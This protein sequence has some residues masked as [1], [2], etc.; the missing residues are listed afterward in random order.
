MGRYIAQRLVSMVPVVLLA[1]VG[2][3]LFFTTVAGRSRR[4]H[5]RHGR[6][7]ANT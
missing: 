2:V 3:F 4:L 1:S 5:A 7:C 6:R